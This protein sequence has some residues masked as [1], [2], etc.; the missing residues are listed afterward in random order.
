MSIGSDPRKPKESFQEGWFRTGDVGI[1]EEGYYRIMGRMSTDIIKTG[2]YKVSGLEIEEIL[3]GHPHIADCAVFGMDDPEWGER[4]CAAVVLRDEWCYIVH[5][6][7][8]CLGE[9]A[10]GAV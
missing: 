7:A 4:V 10:N 1:V 6:T 5:G 3:R 8:S 2:G 9:G